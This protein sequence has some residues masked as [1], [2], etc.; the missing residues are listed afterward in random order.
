[1]N[2][3]SPTFDV[4]KRP[5]TL[6]TAGSVLLVAL[7]WWF[8]WMSPQGTKLTTVNA[9][10]STLQTQYSGLLVTLQTDRHQA[11]KVNLYAGYLKMFATAV[12]EVPDAGGLTTDLAD[13]ADSISP[14]LTI[15][16]ITDDTTVAGTPLGTVPLSMTLMGPR[17]DCFA[18]MADLYN[19][20]MMARLITISS[21]NPTPVTT[22]SKGVD[23]LQPSK[24][25]YN[26]SIVGD[27]YFDANIN[28]GAG[29]VVT[30]TLAPT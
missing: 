3:Q 25:K 17:Q 23:V 8:V 30:T 29:V 2:L 21:F 28:P 27:A 16:G 10:I 18:F 13:L 5:V 14:S 1:M 7:L 11:A 15:T 6:I 4:V 26:V 19:R 9:Q 22:G 24:Q 12:P 20:N